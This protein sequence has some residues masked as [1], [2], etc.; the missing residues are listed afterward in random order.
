MAK[1]RKTKKQKDN[2]EIYYLILNLIESAG[3]ADLISASEL[4]LAKDW[5]AQRDAS[6]LVIK[7]GELQNAVAKET[8]N[9]Y[10]KIVGAMAKGEGVAT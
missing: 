2:E 5:L 9:Q 10:F 1:A 6:Y 8:L 7:S 3:A 4:E